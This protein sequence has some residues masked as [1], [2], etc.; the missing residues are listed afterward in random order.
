MSSQKEISR[1]SKKTL[2][3]KTNLSQFYL[4]KSMLLLFGICYDRV[5]K[6]NKCIASPKAAANTGHN[7]LWTDSC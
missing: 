2:R 6:M 5:M 4:G 7:V 1:P 3:P